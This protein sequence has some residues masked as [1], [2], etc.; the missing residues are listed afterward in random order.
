MISWPVKGFI[1]F[2][3]NVSF[4]PLNIFIFSFI[5]T[6]ENVER[7]FREKNKNILTNTPTLTLYI[8][9]VPG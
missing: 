9:P 7:K 5:N 6:K 2:N 4:V 1:G 3:T 8:F